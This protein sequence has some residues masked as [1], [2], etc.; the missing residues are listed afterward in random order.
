[1]IAE[2]TPTHCS[3]IHNAVSLVLKNQKI[4]P[5]MKRMKTQSLSVFFICVHLSSSAV[6]NS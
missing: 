1:M 5:P 2:A 3:S 6:K 4:E